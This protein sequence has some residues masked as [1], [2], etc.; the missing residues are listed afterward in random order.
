MPKS[1]LNL[2][3]FVF[4]EIWVERLV[5]NVAAHAQ[6]R[7]DTT[8]IGM[9]DDEISVAQSFEIV[10]DRFFFGTVLRISYRK[11]K[12]NDRNDRN[13]RIVFSKTIST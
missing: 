4:S 8:G 12:K 5:A 3:S 7:A 10:C 11:T 13:D 2:L 9:I 1:S 6:K